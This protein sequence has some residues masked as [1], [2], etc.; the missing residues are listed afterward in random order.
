MREPTFHLFHANIVT[1]RAPLD[2]P[3]MVD[4]V[5]LTDQ[6]DALAPA[7]PGFVAQPTL[8]DGGAVFTGL[9]LLNVSIWETVESLKQFTYRGEHA[10]AFKRRKEWFKRR[11]GPN[12][13][14]FWIPPGEVSSEAEIK[15]RLDYLA[16]NGPSPF[17]FT[18]QQPFTIQEML[19]YR[20]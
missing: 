15:Q 11:A 16:A 4:F 10:L 5:A 1:L 19:S 6:I 8:P 7:S 2:D 9:S 12:Y 20:R 17:A 14:L 3:L 13:L 18:F